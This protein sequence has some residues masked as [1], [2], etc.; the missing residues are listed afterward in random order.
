MV[1][2]SILRIK[3]VLFYYYRRNYV[4]GVKFG[5]S[6]DINKKKKKKKRLRILSLFMCAK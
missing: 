2:E 6:G 3:I 5:T 4:F 1:V